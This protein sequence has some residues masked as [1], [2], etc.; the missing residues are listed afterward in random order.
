MSQQS[1]MNR[2]MLKLVERITARELASPTLEK[3]LEDII[4]GEDIMEKDR[5]D[6]LIESCDIFD[7]DTTKSKEEAFKIAAERLA[8]KIRVPSKTVLEK[9]FEREKASSTALSPFFAVP[10]VI[11]DGE[12]NF[13]I[14]LVR[15]KKGVFFSDTA[16]NVHAM[17][18][19][20]GTKEQR[21]FHLVALSAIAQIVQD[22]D[23]ETNWLKAKN[24]DELRKLVL[25]AERKRET[26]KE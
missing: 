26:D 9:L 1:G 14:L 6:R 25:K 17:F 2:N 23:F 19:L 8:S 22:S 11:L 3:E 18:F 5:F 13:E 15:S 20:F 21:H 10:H 7:M 4:T 16:P 12:N 24:T